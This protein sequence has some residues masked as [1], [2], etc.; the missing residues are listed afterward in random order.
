MLQKLSA[1]ACAVAVICTA[2]M[3]YAQIIISDFD[4]GTT[5][6][7]AVPGESADFVILNSVTYDS[8]IHATTGDHA[9]N[10]FMDPA[11]GFR[12]AM[13]LSDASLKD[14]IVSHPI[15]EADVSWRSDEWSSDPDG[16]W[17][18][19]DKAS[20][21]NA[22][23]GW[24]EAGD[25]MMTDTANPGF[26]GSWDPVNWGDSHQRTISWDF[27]SAVAGNEA[28]I[29]ASEW[30]QLTLSVNFDANFNTGNGYSFWIDSIRLAPATVIPEPASLTLLGLCGI[31]TLLRRR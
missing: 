17:V 16:T 10:V 9:L 18:R 13:T 2:S 14:L 8:D 15:V 28:A 7:W 20:I 19:W 11:A 24:Q 1:V 4:D 27:S 21:N 25:P 12:W 26:P 3:G 6:G 29:Q 22:A 31:C 30:F 5:Q 23:T